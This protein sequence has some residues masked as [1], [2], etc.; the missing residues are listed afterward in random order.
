MYTLHGVW[1]SCLLAT[2][3]LRV[4]LDGRFA[5]R[6]IVARTMVAGLRWVI[7]SVVEESMVF[8]CRL[9]YIRSGDY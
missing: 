8:S 4:R 3:S 5:G 2:A 1:C 6:V 9:P 7:P